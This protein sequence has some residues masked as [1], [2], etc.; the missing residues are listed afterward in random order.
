MNM[1][2]KLLPLLLCFIFVTG[3]DSFERSTFK[4]L[5]AS[6]AILDTAQ[7]D[8]E[9]GTPIPHNR[10]AYALINNGKAAQVVAVNGMLTYEGIKTAGKDLTAQTVE[11]TADLVALAPL[12]VQIQALISNPAVCTGAK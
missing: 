11:V 5:S 1:M 10:C 4:T 8:Y 9:V 7:A 3:C 2:R 6:K 12:V